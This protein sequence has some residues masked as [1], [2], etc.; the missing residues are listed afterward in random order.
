MSILFRTVDAWFERSSIHVPE[1]EL[2]IDARW[3][4]LRR[5]GNFPL[6]YSAVSEDY[7]STF[8]DERGMI[9]FAQKMGATYALGDPMASDNDISEL[10]PE[11]VGAFGA[12]VFVACQSHTAKAL[13]R[14][15]YSVNALGYDSRLD[16]AGHSFKGG[17][18]KRIRYATSWLATNGMSI[19]E[20]T[21]FEASPKALRQMSH[22]WR[23][24]R[25]NRREI[26]FLNRAFEAQVLPDVRRF[27]A[28]TETGK[29]VGFISFDPV[30]SAGRITGYLASQ[31]RR[32][33]EGSAYLDLAIMRAAIDIFKAESVPSVYLG[34]SPVA[35]IGPAEIGHELGWLRRGFQ[36]A[37]QSNWVNTKFFNSRGLAE[38]KNRFRGH[39]I[40]LY[41][42][43]PP[44]GS[45]LLK[46]IGFLRLIS[47]V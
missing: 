38:Y 28:V 17:T 44:K 29:V 5:H 15:G 12:P 2:P 32:L 40:P 6:A 26:R 8:G 22:K 3:E 7:L 41:I 24:T 36:A 10:L 11:F 42:C 19:V 20:E 9:M 37:H 16:L 47:L 30:F 43:L 39:R 34:I 35:G 23:K 1:R 4:I 21:D 13:S 33:P 46:V 25:V 45:R 18:F 14:L 27:F 31:K